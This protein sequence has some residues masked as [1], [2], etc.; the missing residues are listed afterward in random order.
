MIDLAR[1]Q[2]SCNQVLGLG[3]ESD[4]MSGTEVMSVPWSAML[5]NRVERG[6]PLAGT[7]N[8]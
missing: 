7:C 4:E 5:Y 1:K 3:I 6:C 2:V 8:R